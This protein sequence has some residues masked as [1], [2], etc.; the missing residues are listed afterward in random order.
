MSKKSSKNDWLLTIECSLDVLVLADNECRLVL[1]V[2]GEPQLVEVS[3]PLQQEVH[4][5]GV[6][7]VASIVQWRP[8][9]VVEG[10]DVGS[11][12]Q[13]DLDA[14]LGALLAGLVEW[15]AVLLV[16]R[17]LVGPTFQQTLHDLG[18]VVH[19]RKVKGSFEKV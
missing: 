15:G 7:V 13:Q 12:L 3:L 1:G 14:V 4:R 9:S 18:V 10:H 2:L 5:T 11:L 19:C 6:P 17:F 8:F 16:L